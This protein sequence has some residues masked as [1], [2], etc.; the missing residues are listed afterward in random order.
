MTCIGTDQEQSAF[1]RCYAMAGSLPAWS[2]RHG[3]P[4]T[5]DENPP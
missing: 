4:E 5:A 1:P 2:E 3:V